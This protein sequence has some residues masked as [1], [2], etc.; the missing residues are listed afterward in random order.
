VQIATFFD[1][2]RAT[3]TLTTLLDAGYDGTL[4]SSESDGR[5]VFSVQLGPFDDLSEAERASETLDA[6]YG[7]ASSV[8]VLRRDEP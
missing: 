7:F 3:E 8:T 2:T 5:L 4:V 1:E 6:A